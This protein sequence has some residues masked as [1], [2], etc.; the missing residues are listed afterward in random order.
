MSLAAYSGQSLRRGG[1]GVPDPALNT[2]VDHAGEDCLQGDLK[3]RL[4]DLI[5][6]EWLVHPKFMRGT[7]HRHDRPALKTMTRTIRDGR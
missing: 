4:C 7:L 6:P 3:L 1:V 5:E 2:P